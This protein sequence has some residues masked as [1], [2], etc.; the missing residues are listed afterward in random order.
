L[1]LFTASPHKPAR[2]FVL[3]ERQPGTDMTAAHSRASEVLR[4]LVQMHVAM[5]DLDKQLH[6]G[7]QPDVQAP[8]ARRFTA[9]EYRCLVPFTAFAELSPGMTRCRHGDG[10]FRD[11]TILMLFRV[12]ITNWYSGVPGDSSASTACICV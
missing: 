3:Y 4:D 10:T 7:L 2:V 9:R 11:N 12:P 1:Q 8:H 6:R 5:I